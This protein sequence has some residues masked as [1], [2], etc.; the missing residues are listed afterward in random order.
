MNIL[1]EGEKEK[2]KLPSNPLRRPPHKSNHPPPS[3]DWKP[4]LDINAVIYG[5]IYLFY[6]PNPADP[7]NHAAA[8]LLR[9]NKGEFERNVA[10]SLRGGYVDGV[11]YEQLK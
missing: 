6:D 2:T 7:L 1:R 3:P 11:Q 9:E 8:K 4:V 5:L 10:R